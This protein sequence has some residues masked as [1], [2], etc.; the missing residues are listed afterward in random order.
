MF[1]RFTGRARRSIVLAQEEARN[2]QHNYIGTEHI[3]LGLLNEGQG[4]GARALAQSGVTLDNVRQEVTDTIGLGQS[5]P[6]G[7]IPFTPRAKKV[8]ELA[9][10]EALALHHNYIGT[11]HIL[12]GLIREGDGVAVQ[13][14]KK[15]ADPAQFRATIL[16]ILGATYAVG[17]GRSR[18]WLRRVSAAI[19]RP[20]E[21][22]IPEAEATQSQ[23][24]ATPAADVTLTTAAQLAGG[25]P[26]GSHH[27]LLAALTDANSAAA[28]VLASLGV[29]LTRAKDALHNADITGT[30]DELPEEAGRRQLNIEVTGEIVTIVATD[31]ILVQSANAALKALNDRAGRAGRASTAGTAGQDEP[32]GEQT[33]AATESG[34]TPGGVIRGADLSGLPASNLAKAWGALHDSLSAIAASAQAA[35]Q[36][37]TVREA[38]ERARAGQQGK[39]GPQAGSGTEATPHTEAGPQ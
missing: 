35:A 13:I 25:D 32:G 9:L 26:V 15:H 18:N 27:L 21:G 31:E 11:E 38:S 4:V 33:P 3:L 14:L 19:G 37:E 28:R 24:S 1:E 30:S 8:L 7:H 17:E 6:A 29:D 12:L 16:D 23:L 2:L 39:S 34:G 5:A 36:T 10:R 20:A 22:D